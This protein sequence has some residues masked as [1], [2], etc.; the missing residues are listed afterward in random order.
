MWKTPNRGADPAE[1]AVYQGQR[2]HE[3][4]LNRATSAFEHALL[5]PLFILNGGG[6]VAFLTLLGATSSKDSSLQISPSSAAWAVGLWATGLFVA[7]VGV[8]FAYLSQRS[9]SRAVRHRRSLI[10]HAMLAPDSRLH[11]VLLEVGAVDLTQLM[12]RG[13]RQQLE[14]LTSVAVSLALFVAGAAAAAVA[15]I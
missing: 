9:L 15:V 7:A 1:L 12:K 8:L 3:L 4:E 14:W 6:A 10:E 2:A 5:S 13:R 11:P